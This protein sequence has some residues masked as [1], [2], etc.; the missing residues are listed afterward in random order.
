VNTQKGDQEMQ[1][2]NSWR[3]ADWK[4]PA[5]TR[6]VYN[7]YEVGADAMLEALRKDGTPINLISDDVFQKL[8]ESL[9][10]KIMNCTQNPKGTLV[11]IPDDKP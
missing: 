7:A 1:K 5:Q 6:L 9:D 8:N 11:F 10:I 4:N 3:P 2:D